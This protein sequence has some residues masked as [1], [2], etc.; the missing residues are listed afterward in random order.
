[1]LRLESAQ[2]R[3]VVSFRLVLDENFGYLC[4]LN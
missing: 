2:S 4:R 1:M 3:V